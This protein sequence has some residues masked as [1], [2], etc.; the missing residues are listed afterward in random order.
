MKILKQCNILLD[1]FDERCKESSKKAM[2]KQNSAFFF[3]I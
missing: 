2:K 3:H 1:K